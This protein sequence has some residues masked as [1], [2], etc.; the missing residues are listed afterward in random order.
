MRSKKTRD[1]IRKIAEDENLTIRQIEDIVNSPFRFT[2]KL[3]SKG[4]RKTMEFPIIRL[5]K[6]GTFRPRKGYLKAV[7]RMNKLRG[8]EKSN[9]N[10]KRS[11]D[12]Q[13]GSVD[14]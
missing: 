9:R 5:F 11:I 1:L 8:H 10:Y 2:S 6:F 3:M 12:N 7:D 4:N 13:S 14:D